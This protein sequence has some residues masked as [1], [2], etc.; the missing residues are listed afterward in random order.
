MKKPL[1]KKHLKGKTGIYRSSSRL[2]SADLAK[3]YLSLAR[4]LMFRKVAPLVLE[5]PHKGNWGIWMLFMRDSIDLV[6][7]DERR[8]V[9]SVHKDLN[10]LSLDPSTW[11]IYYPPAPVKYAIELPAGTT[12]QPGNTLEFR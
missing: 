9:V 6:F 11:R 4:G 2:Y 10:P 8:K 1:T 5:F 7:L 3:S 12:I